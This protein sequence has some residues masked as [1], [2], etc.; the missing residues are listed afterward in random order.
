RTLKTAGFD[1]EEADIAAPE[2]MI[3]FVAAAAVAAVTIMQLVRSRDGT[4][5]EQLPTL[6]NSRTSLC[7]KPCLLNS[8][9]LPRSKKPAPKG[10]PRLRCMGHCSAWRMDRLLRK[11]RPYGDAN[12]S[13]SLPPHQ[14]RNNSTAP[15]CVN[16]IAEWRAS[17]AHAPVGIDTTGAV[18]PYEEEYS[19]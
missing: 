12:R 1:I 10:Y 18:Q 15:K 9:A 2:V 6:L 8:R 4:T 14:I 19:R 3:K 11:T 7:S 5:Q 16:R 13:R 17:A